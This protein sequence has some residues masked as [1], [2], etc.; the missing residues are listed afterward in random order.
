MDLQK[1]AD[2]GKVQRPDWMLV[3][4]EVDYLKKGSSEKNVTLEAN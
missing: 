2:K 1:E 4:P 3:P